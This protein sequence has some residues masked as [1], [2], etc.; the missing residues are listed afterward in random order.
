MLSIVNVVNA[1]PV[2]IDGGIIVPT[3]VGERARAPI[4]AAFMAEPS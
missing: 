4:A 1:P 3:A 2:G